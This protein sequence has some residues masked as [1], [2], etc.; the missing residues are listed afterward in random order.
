MKIVRSISIEQAIHD[1]IAKKAKK[2][3]RSFS[4]LVNTILEQ[5]VSKKIQTE[6]EEQ[7]CVEV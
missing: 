1:K 7:D 4:N 6:E 5:A 2:E 3:H